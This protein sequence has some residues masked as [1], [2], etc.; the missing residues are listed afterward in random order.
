MI[1]EQH[2]QEI[3][4]AAVERKASQ[5]GIKRGLEFVNGGSSALKTVM[6]EIKKRGGAKREEGEAIEEYDAPALA[7]A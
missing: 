4:D 3:A 7:T 2:G 5:A 1:R 6:D